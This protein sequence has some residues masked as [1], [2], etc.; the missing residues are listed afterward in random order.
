MSKPLSPPFQIII[1]SAPSSPRCSLTFSSFISSPKFSFHLFFIPGGT[2]QRISIAVLDPFN[3][4]HILPISVSLLCQPVRIHLFLLCVQLVIYD[5]TCPWFGLCHMPSPWPASPWSYSCLLS[6]FLSPTHFFLLIF[7]L[8]KKKSLKACTSRSFQG[9][10]LILGLPSCNI[11]ELLI[12][13]FSPTFHCWL[14]ST[15][16]SHYI[17]RHFAIYLLKPIFFHCSKFAF[18]NDLNIYFVAFFL[19]SIYCSVVIFYLSRGDDG[20]FNKCNENHKPQDLFCQGQDI[21]TLNNYASQCLV[22][23]QYWNCSGVH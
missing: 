23:T 15:L 3:R 9:F 20:K 6:S 13:L 12:F 14:I 10:T 22:F 1:R 7:P 5:V 4:L 16:T 19:S 21:M 18:Y 2:C 11:F 8:R 17:C